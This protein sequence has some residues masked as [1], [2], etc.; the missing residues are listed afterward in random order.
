[1][2]AATRR[3]SMKRL[4]AIP[5]LI[6][7]ALIALAACGTETSISDEPPAQSS[8]P[9]LERPTEI[10]AADGPVTATAIVLD[11]GDGPVLCLGGVDESLPPRCDGPAVEGWDWDSLPDG[12][13]SERGTRWGRW[14]VTGTFDGTTF[15]LT[16]A[17]AAPELL[18]PDAVDAPRAE[19][20]C[21]PPKEGWEI[22]DPEKVTEEAFAAGAHAA[23]KLPDL[24]FLRLDHSGSRRTPEQT[25]SDPV[26][27]I[28][29]VSDW[30]IRVAVTEDPDRA[31]AVIREH[32]GGPLCVTTAVATKAE[33]RGIQRDLAD[34]PGLLGSWTGG[35]GVHVQV[36]YDDGSI[37]AWADQE[38]GDGVVTVEPALRAA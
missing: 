6:A 13:E 14:T 28:A 26:A 29:L 1:M 38:Y 7:L 22:A 30:L 37:Q 27:G 3:T 18:E 16:E 12:H 17:P 36:A 8:E 15:T 32:W 33:L 20:E 2:T 11:D 24:A 4:I 10:P 23:S 19:L 25:Y 21:V 5:P 34:L 35:S 9:S 31:E